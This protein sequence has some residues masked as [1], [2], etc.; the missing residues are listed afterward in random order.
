MKS[1][2]KSNPKDE[3]GSALLDLATGQPLRSLSRLRQAQSSQNV[4][5]SSKTTRKLMRSVRDKAKALA[6]LDSVLGRADD[7]NEDL[8]V[9]SS[10][11]RE[12]NQKKNNAEDT[13]KR[14]SSLQARESHIASSK[15]MSH[16][17]N[18]SRALERMDS[19]L[20]ELSSQNAAAAEAVQAAEAKRRAADF[21]SRNRKKSRAIRAR[22]DST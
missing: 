7:G 2:D 14:K 8:A 9:E 10:Q 19:G 15:I 3:A 22:L 5:T 21:A 13:E 11:D 17:R 16:A 4:G 6:R 18:K 12:S 20:T 1:D